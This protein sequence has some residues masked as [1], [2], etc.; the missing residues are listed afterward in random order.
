MR[1]PL[2]TLTRN[3]KLKLAALTLAVLLWVVVS[4]EQIT[5]QWI[6][7]PVRITPR[8]SAFVV[9]GGPVPRVVEVRF[10]GPGREL[11]EL[12]LEDPV[13]VLPI[14]EVER[15]SQ[16][17][18]LDPRMVRIP[19]GLSVT[20]LD[21][22]PSSARVLFQRLVTREV[23]VRV[24]IGRR[25]RER[26]VVED[27]LRVSP[28]RVRVTGPADRVA[29]LGAVVT[30]P[31]DFN[32][33][34]SAFSRVLALDRDSLSGVRASS[35]TVR[36]TGSVD[37]VVERLVPGVAVVPPAGVRV[38]PTEVEVRVT[39]PSR[40]VRALAPASLRAV[41]AIDSLPRPLPGDGVPVPVVVTDLPPGLGSRTIPALVRLFPVAPTTSPD[42]A[43]PPDGVRP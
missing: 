31:L 32:P 33:G 23:P 13:L 1:T 35:L 11:W 9:T 28:T 18:P 3:W 6:E 7:V 30:R 43:A 29:R 40:Q 34:D 4:A 41:M 14:D 12:A 36:V 16:L 39:G 2:R 21:V 22:R 42:S 25:S 27:T 24:R 38:E 10:A 37:R 5:T 15:E 17:F 19:N 8:D 20:P 26:Y